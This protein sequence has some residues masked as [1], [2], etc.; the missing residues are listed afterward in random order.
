M[1]GCHSDKIC[2]QIFLAHPICKAIH[3]GLEGGIM[4]AKY[5]G[6]EMTSFGPLIQG[7]HSPDEKVQISS[8]KKF[9]GL[10]ARIL[11]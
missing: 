1:F 8:V 9:W 7:A 10:L 6:M 3:A 4:K 11:Q 5:S 2:Y